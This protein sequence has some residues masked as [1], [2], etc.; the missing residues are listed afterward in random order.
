M[1]KGSALKTAALRACRLRPVARLQ[2]SLQTPICSRNFMES[3]SD[4]PLASPKQHKCQDREASAQRVRHDGPLYTQQQE[5]SRYPSRADIHELFSNLTNNPSAFFDRVAPDVDWTVMGTHPCAGR[6]KSLQDFQK[7]TL[8]RLAKIMR[9]PG[10]Q[11]KPRNVI[12]G[13]DQA[14]CTVELVVNAVCKNGQSSVIMEQRV[15][16]ADDCRS[17]VRQLLCLVLSFR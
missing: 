3:S 12:G 8:Q 11:L 17:C 9:E 1:Q 5:S 13:G 7:A 2:S 15:T 10:I 14:W 4:W 6:Y 16:H